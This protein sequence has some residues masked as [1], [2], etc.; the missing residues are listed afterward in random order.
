M[1]NLEE[2]FPE[3][4]LSEYPTI[5]EPSTVDFQEAGIGAVVVIYG[6]LSGETGRT[7]RFPWTCEIR[8][9]LRSH[10]VAFTNL[11]RSDCHFL[12]RQNRHPRG[13]P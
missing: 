10:E 7:I 4:Q 1:K 6:Q 8:K 2:R 5:D 12:Y 3:G 11:W 9:P 13:R